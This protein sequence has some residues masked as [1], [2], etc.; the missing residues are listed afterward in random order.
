MQFTLGSDNA[1]IVSARNDNM[2]VTDV[3]MDDTNGKTAE[4]D[5]INGNS[6]TF[7]DLLGLGIR[8]FMTDSPYQVLGYLRAKGLHQ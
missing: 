3:V 4:A 7:D 6:K 5:L 1:A 2:I 8:M